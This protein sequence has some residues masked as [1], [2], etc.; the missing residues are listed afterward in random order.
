M[1]YY[2]AMPLG[3]FPDASGAARVAAVLADAKRA[4]GTHERKIEPEQ[5]ERRRVKSIRTAG[6]HGGVAT[7]KGC[8][9]YGCHHAKHGRA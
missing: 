9:E 2:V 1:D 5:R 3:Q 8:A 7:R 6:H 4:L